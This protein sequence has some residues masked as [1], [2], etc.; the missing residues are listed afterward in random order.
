[1]KY[2]QCYATAQNYRKKWKEALESGK[3]AHG[4]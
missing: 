2:F 1:M 3:S 4:F